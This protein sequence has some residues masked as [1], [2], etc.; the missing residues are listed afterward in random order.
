MSAS[1]SRS[2]WRWRARHRSA[3][4]RAGRR[5]ALGR[6]RLRA[7]VDRVEF[8][9]RPDPARRA[10]DPRRRP[11]RGEGRG[12]LRAPHQ[13]ARDRDRDVRAR[14]R[15]HP[16]LRVDHRRGEELD[17]RQHARPPHHQGRRR[18]RQRSR[19]GARDP[20]RLRRRASARAASSRRRPLL[21]AGSATAR[22]TSSCSASC[23]NCRAGLVKSDIQLAILRR[24]RAAGIGSRIRSARCGSSRTA[25]AF[26]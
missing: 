16:E 13:R 12:R 5:R 8:R 18:L 7:A 15:H 21:L 4:D 23:D 1:S 24:F 3:E 26:G 25:A 10:A 11:D 19:Q 20:D 6:H 22:S 9:L 14:E 17:P 2:C